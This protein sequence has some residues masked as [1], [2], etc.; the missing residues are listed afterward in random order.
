MYTSVVFSSQKAV[1]KAAKTAGVR[2]VHMPLQMIVFDNFDISKVDRK[3]VTYVSEPY[4]GLT[5]EVKTGL[6]ILIA[7]NNQFLE[8]LNYLK[9]TNVSIT[10]SFVDTNVIIVRI[11]NMMTWSAFAAKLDKEASSLIESAT[12]DITIPV[13]LSMPDDYPYIQY[14]YAQHGW[15]NSIQAAESQPIVSTLPGGKYVAILDTGCDINHPDL[16]DRTGYN[17][18]C[19][20]NN[21]NVDG[22]L[23]DE[24]YNPLTDTMDYNYPS[25]ATALAGIVAANSSNG[26]LVQSNTYNKVKAQVLKVLYPFVCAVDEVDGPVDIELVLPNLVFCYNSTTA[27]LLRAFNRALANPNCEAIS[28]SFLGIDFPETVTNVM[29]NILNNSRNCKGIPIFLAAGNGATDNYTSYAAP[30]SLAE[31]NKLSV[32]NGT[33][34]GTA[35]PNDSQL[36]AFSNFGSPIFMGAPAVNVLTTDMTN[37]RGYSNLA[38]PSQDATYFFSGTSASAPMVASVA[39]MMRQVNPNLTVSNIRNILADTALQVGGYNYGGTVGFYDISA[40]VSK[41]GELGYGLLDQNAA[42]MAAAEFETVQEGS[43]IE[44]DSITVP[45]TTVGAG[46]TVT[47]PY[48]IIFSPAYI[49]QYNGC[50][51]NG[52]KVS[53]YRSA[54]AYYTTT[55]SPLIYETII[56]PEA[57]DSN[58]IGSF[59]FTIPCGTNGNIYIIGKVDSGDAYHEPDEENNMFISNSFAVNGSVPSCSVTDLSITVLSSSILSSGYRSFLL[60]VTNTGNTTITTFNWTRGW[61]NT[62]TNSQTT[63]NYNFSSTN[64]LQPGQ[65]RNIN[66]T[67]AAYVASFP[68]TWFAR[69]NTVNGAPDAVITNNLS[70]ITINQ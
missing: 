34:C 36:A 39:A 17:W 58:Y 67:W 12:Q 62:A 5:T 4:F 46:S 59:N 64:P 61:L 50:L 7:A 9:R 35:D 30:L 43:D 31:N 14:T 18:N 13:K 42:L 53:F 20:N 40:V 52:I 26:I 15:L 68:A 29:I 38:N 33:C 10:D 48:E 24:Y 49:E 63:G 23:G 47:V 51:V 21:G 45:N 11:P 3:T 57:G 19:I 69:I 66:V 25:H 1:L 54:N 2:S 60:K 8:L 41:S 37:A 6:G 28:I 70:T 56:Y 44:F 55:G 27:A 16:V 32:I 22:Q 65:S